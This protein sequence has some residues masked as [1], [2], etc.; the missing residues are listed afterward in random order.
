MARELPYILAVDILGNYCLDFWLSSAVLWLEVIIIFIVNNKV[1]Q[2]E[3]ALSMAL[4]MFVIVVSS[5]VL[6]SIAALFGSVFIKGI[7]LELLRI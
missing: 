5:L 6:I 7:R 3:A 2:N 4:G 1:S